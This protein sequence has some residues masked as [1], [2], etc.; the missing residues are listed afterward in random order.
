MVVTAKP[1]K[2]I[3]VRV[4]AKRESFQ[5]LWGRMSSFVRQLFHLL[6][7]GSQGRSVFLGRGVIQVVGCISAE[8]QVRGLS[9]T[10]QKKVGR[11]IW[12]VESGRDGEDGEDIDRYDNGN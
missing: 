9:S 1:K 10:K 3:F 6:I 4:V 5:V 2:G 11:G 7:P 8:V 12:C